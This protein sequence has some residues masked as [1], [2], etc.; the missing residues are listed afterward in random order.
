[1]L[2]NLLPEV[3][4]K[5]R[6]ET[7]YLDMLSQEMLEKRGILEALVA[8]LGITPS[9]PELVDK[10]LNVNTK[11]RTLSQKTYIAT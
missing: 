8:R 3:N 2:K 9:I 1:M 7:S 10:L 5:W 6:L 4:E 11:I